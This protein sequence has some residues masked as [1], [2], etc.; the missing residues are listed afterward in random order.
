[1]VKAGENGENG[2]IVGATLQDSEYNGSTASRR[3][4]GTR[5]G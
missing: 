3:L 4:A 2:G 5:L 1:M